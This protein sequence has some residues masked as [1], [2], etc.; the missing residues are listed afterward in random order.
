MPKWLPLMRTGEFTD[1]H[2]K[3]YT[4][5]GKILDRIAANFSADSP[6]HLVVGHPDKPSVPSFGIVD[7][8]KIVGDK[9]FFRPAKVVREFAALVAKGGFPAVSAGLDKSLSQLDH[10]AFLS[11]QRPAIDGLEPICE[12]EAAG[13]VAAT[14][15]L[16][17]SDYLLA[18]KAEFAADS[19]VGWR[20]Q[21]VGTLFRKIRDYFIEKDGVEAAD[22]II[23]SYTIDSIASDPPESIAENTQ[24]S[25]QGGSM[26]FE[27]KYEA[28]QEKNAELTTKLAEFSTQAQSDK[29][30]IDALTAENETLKTTVAGLTDKQ[31]KAEFEAYAEK[32][33]GEKKLLPAEKEQTVTTLLTMHKASQAA[34]FCAEGATSPLDLYKKEIEARKVSIPDGGHTAKGGPEF[35]ADDDPNA[36]G[37]AAGRYIDE[38]AAKGVAV[39][40]REAVRHVTEKK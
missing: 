1:R 35:S 16:D 32:L 36:I 26:D 7:K 5:T 9:L 40:A 20:L 23:P 15:S 39:S 2:G 12:F 17:V 19:W 25:K 29:D 27:K 31:T 22:R 4:I 38:Q 11:G 30:K 18:N 6:A 13:D 8:L 24:F 14:V 10:I 28:E 21:D 34:E 3:S 33:V 37:E